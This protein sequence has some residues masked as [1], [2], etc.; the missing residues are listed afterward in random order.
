MERGGS[1]NVADPLARG[2]HLLLKKLGT[3]KWEMRNEEMRK[4]RNKGGF[5]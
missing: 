2:Y 5:I 1:T 4:S 3:R